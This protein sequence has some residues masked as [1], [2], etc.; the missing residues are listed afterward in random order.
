MNR[1]FPKQADPAKPKPQG[2]VR[3]GMVAEKQFFGFHGIG[4]HWPCP[5]TSTLVAYPCIL[6]WRQE[7]AKLATSEAVSPEPTG[8]AFPFFLNI[9]KNG[10][11][12]GMYCLDSG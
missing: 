6:F 7:S 9:L 12:S 2:Q 3:H 1:L 10:S 4:A 8:Y 5:E 11:S